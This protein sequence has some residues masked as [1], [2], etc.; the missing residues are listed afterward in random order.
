MK[1]GKH[2]LVNTTYAHSFVKAKIV[3]TMEFKSKVVVTRGLEEE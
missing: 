3:A 2:K 1:Q